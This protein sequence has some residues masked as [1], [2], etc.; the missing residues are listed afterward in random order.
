MGNRATPS[1]SFNTVKQSN[2]AQRIKRQQQERRVLL[3]ICVVV[4]AILLS[5]LVFLICSIVD[6]VKTNAPSGNDPSKKDPLAS[7]STGQEL[8]YMSVTQV[9][10]AIRTG[11]LLVVNGSYAYEFPTTALGLKN[12]YDNRVKFD[13]VSNTYMVGDASWKLHSTALDAFNAMMLK[14]Y[15]VYT[16]GTTLITS[17]YRTYEA[18]DALNS[19]VAA[20]YSDHHTG[21]CVSLKKQTATGREDLESDHWIY[22]NCHKYGFIVR[23]PE[24]KS[25]ITGV[26]GYAYCLRY[27]G[28]AHATYI[29]QNDLCLEEYVELLKTTYT[30]SNHLSVTGADGKRYEVY[31]VT[32]TGE[33]T[34]IQ[35]PK[36]YKYSISGDNMSGFIVTV[37]LDDAMPIS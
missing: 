19:S 8:T 10:T 31:H 15:E 6:T 7:T 17:A 13:G 33:V 35:V 2:R 25:D 5:L 26:G 18:Q 34:T 11:E 1:R 27:V 22:Q 29:Y 28:V 36:N 3:S 16:D 32:S 9:N 37:H 12:I 23:Y 4:A 20:G 21:L 30:A 24:A 14:Y